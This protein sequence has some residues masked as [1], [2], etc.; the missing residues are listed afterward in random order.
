MTTSS[1]SSSSEEEGWMTIFA[2]VTQMSQSSL[3][4]PDFPKPT[5]SPVPSPVTQITQLSL[6]APQPGNTGAVTWDPSLVIPVVTDTSKTTFITI[7]PSAHIEKSGSILI[8]PGAGETVT[9]EFPH[10]EV[11]G[12]QI[13][14]PP[15]ETTKPAAT[16]DEHNDSPGVTSTAHT[17]IS[18][19][20]LVTPGE[21]GGATRTDG[22]QDSTP[23]A[24]SGSNQNQDDDNSNSNSN[25]DDQ[26]TPQNETPS[27]FLIDNT[28]IIAGGSPITISGKTI[29]LSP[30]GSVVLNGNTIPVTTSDGRLIPAPTGSSGDDENNND[31][32]SSESSPS[33]TSPPNQTTDRN[34]TATTTSDSSDDSQETVGAD[35]SGSNTAD[36]AP[37]AQTDNS[38]AVARGSAW[39]AMTVVIAAFG[40]LAAWI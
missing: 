35:S 36:A 26:N 1:S 8:L 39:S 19:S 23:T 13:D 32:S 9:A 4:M 5:H 34:P 17:E 14:R 30:S 31:E 11:P 28:P 40:G 7:A 16:A 6:E 15:S 12:S 25:N 37:A 21:S 29:S 2:P 3:D 24:G 33:E 20:D 10:I 22:G 27:T 38:S 18:G